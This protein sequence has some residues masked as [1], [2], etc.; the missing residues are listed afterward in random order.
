MT[1]MRI[2]LTA[3]ALAI[4][5]ACQSPEGKRGRGGGPGGDV[6]NRDAIIQIHAGSVMYHKVPCLLPED[7]CTGPK[8]ASGLPGDF[9]D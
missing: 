7:Q 8:P 3:G 5:A 1:R 9:P 4:C 2:G 6:R